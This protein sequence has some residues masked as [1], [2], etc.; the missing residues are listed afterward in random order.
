MC[1]GYEPAWEQRGRQSGTLAQSLWPGM[2][3]L[4]AEERTSPTLRVAS[5]EHVRR[6]SCKPFRGS[7]HAQWCSS[8]GIMALAENPCNVSS[9]HKAAGSICPADVHVARPA[10]VQDIRRS[11]VTAWHSP[12]HPRPI[13]F[14]LA[15]H[16]IGGMQQP[17]F[18][19]VALHLTSILTT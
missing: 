15:L 11:D 3:C 14:V 5:T 10:M 8:P 12:K 16:A 19:L 18:S 6:L 13:L 17:S 4:A 2:A 1:I 9:S 7:R